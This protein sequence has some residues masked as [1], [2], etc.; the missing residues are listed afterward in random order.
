M[1]LYGKKHR[2]RHFGDIDRRMI[3]PRTSIYNDHLLTIDKL[4]FTITS[5]RNG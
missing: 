4:Q 2:H 3:D 1:K 5:I